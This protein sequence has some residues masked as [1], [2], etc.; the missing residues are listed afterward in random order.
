MPTKKT[1][2][3]HK[4]IRKR[5]FKK[6]DF[7]SGDGML[8]SVWGPSLWHYLHTLSFNYPI[9]PTEKQKKA[10]KEQIAK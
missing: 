7:I 2:K 6:K 9:H 3:K 4:K 1:V 8:T 5:T 10:H